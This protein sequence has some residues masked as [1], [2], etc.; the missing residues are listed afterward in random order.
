MQ[1]PLAFADPVVIEEVS[2]P[3]WRELFDAL[4]WPASLLGKSESLTYDEIV[5]SFQRDVLSDELLQA[6]ETLHDLGTPEGRETISEMLA[7]RQIPSGT[8]P[9]GLG[10]RELALRLF[11]SQRTDGALA[12]VFSRAQIQI[13]EGNHRRFNDFIGKK[14]KHIRDL[15]SKRQT[16]ERAILEYCQQADLGNHVQLRD[17]D[18]DDGTCRFQIMRSHHTRTPLAVMDGFASRAKIQYRPVH[19]DLVRYEPALGRLRITARAS[20]IVQF[21]RK[22]FGRVLFDDETFFDGPPVCSLSVLQ[23][24]GRAALANH[25]VF[26]VGRVWMTECIW[27]RGDRERLNFYAADCFDSIE[28][29]KLPLS[30]GQLLQAKFKIEV[31]GKSAR[32]VTVTVRVPS[33]IEVSQV[34]HEN[35]V[36]EVLSAIGI[37][38]IHARA[39]EHDLW[40]LYPWRQPISTWR[41]CFGADTDSLVKKGV[42]AKTQLAYIEPAAHSGAGRILQAEQISPI[43]FLGVSLTPEIPSQSLSA[44]DLDGLELTVPAFQSHL[45]EVLS[46]TGN[47]TPWPA[48]GWFLDLGVLSI[49]EHEFRISYALRQPPRDAAADIKK[50]SAST[51]PVLLLP[52]GIKDSTGITEILLDKALPDCQRVVRDII[53]ASNLVGQVSALLTAPRNARLIV[54]ARLGKIWFDGIEIAELK[55]ETQAFRFVEILAKSASTPIN[56][57][58]LAEQLSPGREDGDQAARSAKTAANKLIKAALETKGLGFEDPF[59]S[60]NGRYRLTV[61]A[62]LVD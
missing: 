11:L 31:I 22:V 56:K 32:P 25:G 19:A 30:E 5:L 50:L 47:A 41:Y 59:R 12:E 26:G 2:L 14:P 34:S 62:W 39:S 16:L 42:L 48:D 49:C 17:F 3:L 6:I 52:K 13:Q 54:D 60:E 57:H 27:E 46:I 61:P 33:R 36:N 8:L 9:Q 28:R 24:R 35:L 1:I 18:D 58:D 43:E 29:L 15:P 44:T 38:D 37:R 7:D 40:N 45:R 55:P 23:N 53:A 10:E 21:Y 51:T 20:S 4:G